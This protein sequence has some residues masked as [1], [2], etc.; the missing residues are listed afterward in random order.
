EHGV[1]YL[2][3]EVG[4]GKTYQALGV[5]A[6]VWAADPS[7]RILVVAPSKAVQ[8]SWEKTWNTFV[9]QKLCEYDNRLADSLHHRP[10][11]PACF[12][13]NLVEFGKDVVD[14]PRRLFLTRISSFSSVRTS[15]NARG[16]CEAGTELK[17][18]EGPTP[19][20]IEEYLDDY[21]LY[22]PEDAMD[23][24]ENFKACE[25]GTTLRDGLDT[26]LR[27]STPINV[28][29]ARQMRA[30][31]PSFDLV[32]LDEGHKMRNRGS[33]IMTRVFSTLLGFRHAG[34]DGERSGGEMPRLLSMSATPAHTH[35][36]DIFRVFGFRDPE[37]PGQSSAPEPEQER[38]VG[39]R[40]V[41]RLRL[42]SGRSKYDYR[43]E[44]GRAVLH[45]DDDGTD[46]LSEKEQ[47]HAELVL[48]L[49][50]K[51]LAHAFGDERSDLNTTI[52]TGFLET[53]ESFEDPQEAHREIEEGSHTDIDSSDQPPDWWVL[54]G[55]ARQFAEQ[56]E[57]GEMPPHPKLA[58]V[59]R[60][61]RE[62]ATADEPEKLLLFVRRR[63]SVR[64]LARRIASVYDDCIL[65]QLEA[66]YSDGAETGD[67]DSERF[68]SAEEFQRYVH[69]TF[70]GDPGPGEVD[71]LLE[72]AATED[73]EV[74]RHSRILA[75]F[76][77]KSD[78]EKAGYGFRNRFRDEGG[79]SGFFA[80]NRLRF[81][82]DVYRSELSARW[83]SYEAFVDSLLD[84]AT[85]TG[86]SE[87]LAGGQ[88]SPVRDGQGNLKRELLRAI[89]HT[90]LLERAVEET[91]GEVRRI[92]EVCRD[93]VVKRHQAS[94]AF[95]EG[96]DLMDNAQEDSSTGLHETVGDIVRHHSVWDR[97][98]ERAADPESEGF[99]GPLADLL[100]DRERPS[101]KGLA[102]VMERR[103]A[104]LD[105]LDKN[106]RMSVG[107]VDLF[108]AYDRTIRG[109]GGRQSGYAETMAE[110]FADWLA[111][112][113]TIRA[114]RLGYRMNETV[115]IFD[116]LARQVGVSED[117]WFEDKVW[118]DFEQQE[119][120]QDV[121]GGSS[122]RS[123]VI[124]QF[125]SP[126]FP[127]FVATTSVFR[128][129][130]DLHLSCQRVW[131]YGL[132]HSPGD[133][134]QQS[135]RIDRYFSK[136][137]RDLM[138]EEKRGESEEAQGLKRPGTLEIGYPYVARSIDATQ[139]GRLLRRKLRVQPLM[140]RGL[141][142]DDSSEEVDL[143]NLA[144]EPVDGILEALARQQ[145]GSKKPYPPE[146]LPDA[147]EA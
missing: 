98:R 86:F 129:G 37:A 121:M 105:V 46:V 116:Q 124:S 61:V 17:G 89:V 53:F 74:V 81:V 122:S 128:E 3:D 66:A 71:E 65:E 73:D 142:P 111:A 23:P 126:F 18:D 57:G 9:R 120:V 140:D 119:P 36:K 21:G 19:R 11:H 49:V 82:W 28:E 131:Q 27:D 2:A 92:C 127:D 8:Q 83:T 77:S 118:S 41:R 47:T 42:L 25:T 24:A 31:L 79:L 30:L 113:S 87:L 103:D 29:I 115:R 4:M 137:H 40:M 38:Y 93:L 90:R 56:F 63:A 43:R 62:S 48:A 69:R 52:K 95:D 132:P 50:Q 34:D 85:R 134:E 114:R 5:A 136:V 133:L 70:L 145:M 6:L 13:D 109:E 1:A 75:A 84:G 106:L 141:S 91:N 110:E 45:A 80:E 68:E 60:F 67:E 78:T 100:M 96:L 76:R 33:N 10:V 94:D 16:S 130:V 97:L 147:S 123:R 143:A 144:D 99:E 125:N 107:I 64:E 54:H 104:I 88:E 32:I 72:A 55:L 12:C 35:K 7:A 59:E 112:G 135:G 20:E 58:A 51:R 15:L 146:D 101:E 138:R 102:D 108:V 117:G 22:V 39:R 44:E 139:L 26:E 14:N